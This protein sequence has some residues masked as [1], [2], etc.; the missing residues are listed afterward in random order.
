MAR[1]TPIS[2]LLVPGRFPS[3]QVMYTWGIPVLFHSVALDLAQGQDTCGTKA[4]HGVMCEG[5]YKALLANYPRD[6]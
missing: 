2:Q 1:F 4:Y 6:V 3:F 5:C